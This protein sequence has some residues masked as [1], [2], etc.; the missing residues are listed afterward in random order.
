MTERNTDLAASYASLRSLLFPEGTTFT[1]EE[2][3]RLKTNFREQFIA[4]HSSRTY[5]WLLGAIMCDRS[6]LKN[7]D[8]KLAEIA[9]DR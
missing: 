2:I 6:D 3:T 7:M 1:T 5:T 9:Y 8:L 4:E